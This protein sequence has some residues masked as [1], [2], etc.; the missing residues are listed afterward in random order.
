MDRKAVNRRK[1]LQMA[2]VLAGGPLLGSALGG[3]RSIPGADSSRRF[4]ALTLPPVHVESER[5]IRVVTGLRPYRP[6]GFVIRSE[7]FDNKLVVHNY[8]HGGA[9]V[10][11]SWGCAELAAEKVLESGRREAVA[12]LGCGVIGLSTAI[13]LQEKGYPVTIYARD[14]PPN[15]TSDVAGASWYPGLVVD[16]ERRTESF[17]QQFKQVARLSHRRFQRLVGDEYAVYWRKQ[18]FFADRRMPIPWQ[19][20]ALP[21]LFPDS[22]YLPPGSHPFPRPHAYVDN[23]IFIEMPR[24]LRALMRDFHRFG[25]RLVVRE[26]CSIR[27]VLDLSE[28]LIVNCTGLGAR[29]LFN[30]QELTPLKGQLVVL[31]PQPEIQYALTFDDYYMFPTRHGILL[32]GTHEQGVES[33]IPDPRNTE[34]ILAA[35]STAFEALE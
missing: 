23:L 15:T 7:T 4:S 17:M 20:D 35:H 28:T 16:A 2:T 5:V 3:C 31:L 22:R 14:L 12:I 19:M 24:Y 30:D 6:S 21:E 18:Y 32:G 1:F 27:E 33:L 26:F 29:K 13:H 11:L 9:G 34:R 8:G 10:T 25:G